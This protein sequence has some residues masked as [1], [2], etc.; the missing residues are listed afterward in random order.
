MATESSEDQN[1]NTPSLN[2]NMNQ[3]EEPPQDLPQPPPSP[4]KQQ[5]QETPTAPETLNLEIP[6][7]QD[8]NPKQQEQVKEDFYTEMFSPPRHVPSAFCNSFSPSKQQVQE[9]PTAP[10]TLTLEIPNSQ[11]S[12]P[13]QQ[14]QVE[15]DF[16]TEMFS[17]PRHVPSAFSVTY[18]RR[19]ANRKQ[20]KR[21][22]LVEKKSSKKLKALKQTLKPV[23]FSSLKNTLDLS[24]HESLLKRLGL[25]DFVHLEFDTNIRTDLIAQLI[26][27]YNSN[28]RCSYVNGVRI[29]V[30]RADLA[31]A[32]NLPSNSTSKKDKGNVNV[33]VS[34]GSAETTDLEESMAFVHEIVSN[35]M[36][37]HDDMS[38]LPD[39]VMRVLKYIKEKS[40]EKVDWPTLIWNMMEKELLAGP[41]LRNCY[42][43]S[44]MQCLIKSQKK[45]LLLSEEV[46]EEVG[47]DG[48]GDVKMC[49]GLEDIK[50]SDLEEHKI[51]LSLGQ[52]NAVEL[53]ASVEN[54]LNENAGKEEKEFVGEG[55][56]V[57]VEG[58]RNEQLLLFDEKKI[59][60]EGDKKEEEENGQWFS[61]DKKKVGENE[62]LLRRCT[63]EGVE[64]MDREEEEKKGMDC[65]EVEKKQEVGEGEEEGGDQEDEEEEM[66]EEEQQEEGGFSPPMRGETLEM[67]TSANL[68]QGMEAVQAPTYRSDVHICDDDLP[69]DFLSSRVG[70]HTIPGGS[71]SHF[72]N[73]IKRE[74][75]HDN[76]L[77][78]HSINGG[79]KRMRISWDNKSSSEFYMYMEQMQHLMEKTRML[80]EAKE[81]ACEESNVN[82]QFFLNELQKREGIIEQLQKARYEVEQKRQEEVYR[83]ERELFLMGNILE[84]YRKALKEN[85]KE[86]DEYRARCPLPDEPLYKDVPG[87][88]GLVLSVME[89]EKQRLKQ[90]EEERMNRLLIENKLKDI[91]GGWIAKFEAHKDRVQ[92]MCNRLL[93]LENEVKSLKELLAKR[94]GSETLECAPNE[95]SVP[96]LLSAEKG[97][98]YKYAV[99]CA[100]A[101]GEKLRSNYQRCSSGYIYAVS[102]VD[103]SDLV[104]TCVEDR[105]DRTK[106]T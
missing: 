76:D 34:D 90:E 2:P 29:G 53:K 99:E 98:L 24:R 43:A 100:S 3:N 41:E 70:T 40:F 38:I 39:E 1:P 19:G 59:G 8:S 69:A 28:S 71:S 54:N 16:Y 95:L 26:A 37:L 50:G 62:L 102:N 25:W 42:Y 46:K 86:F 87:G 91:E 49:D 30:N 88:E 55:D 48:D 77:S 21:R 31:R 57:G 64:E 82:Q 66:E 17:P 44:H 83:L 93:D 4:P 51:E 13:K 9:T 45:E 101:A 106:L 6:D 81:Q 20:L 92:Q 67:V 97:V 96:H 56:V 72:V 73:G 63:V 75:L 68:I 65:D 47:E 11:N 74:I 80:Y 15:E 23:P 10:E 27:T 7:S 12:N 105:C 35:W 33:N 94:K 58:N 78:H 5:V 18:T 32:L 52:D 61:D 104:K 14:E 103:Q 84:G 79:N 36:L 22:A 89:L 85:R 60:F